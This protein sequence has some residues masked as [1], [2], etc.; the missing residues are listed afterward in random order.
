[1]GPA[2]WLAMARDEL[3][4]AELLGEHGITSLSCLHADQAVEKA[5]W[6]FH[7]HR[8]GSGYPPKMGRQSVDGSPAE[9]ENPYYRLPSTVHRLEAR[10]GLA[11]A[12]AS[13]NLRSAHRQPA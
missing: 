9:P 3:R 1:M 2:I 10:R 11:S 4:A 5:L 12:L 6:A 8:E 7:V 13:L